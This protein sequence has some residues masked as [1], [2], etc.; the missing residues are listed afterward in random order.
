MSSFFCYF[1]CVSHFKKASKV[2]MYMESS[3]GHYQSE[4]MTSP[5]PPARIALDGKGR[6]MLTYEFNHHP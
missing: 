5:G 6:S 1:V 4:P 3:M 2:D